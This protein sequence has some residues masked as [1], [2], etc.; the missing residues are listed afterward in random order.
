MDRD[1]IK[2]NKKIILKAVIKPLEFLCNNQINKEAISRYN[3]MV[4]GIVIE[5]FRVREKGSRLV[6]SMIPF[7]CAIKKPVNNPDHFNKVGKGLTSSTNNSAY[8]MMPDN[9]TTK[10]LVN[11][12]RFGN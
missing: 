12:K 4:S 3:R 10:K 7:I 1:L 2:T 6:L 11:K 5:I 9:G 8:K